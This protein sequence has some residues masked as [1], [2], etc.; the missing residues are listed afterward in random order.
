MNRRL[1]T[2]SWL[3]V[4]AIA[5]TV[6]GGLAALGSAF[7]FTEA[8]AQTHIGNFKAQVVAGDAS[9]ET[10]DAAIT[11]LEVS[12]DKQN[13]MLDNIRVNQIKMMERFKIRH[14]S[15]RKTKER[16]DESR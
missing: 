7:F 8:D 13:L 12:S 5:L 14:E 1:D 10:Q 4:I 6:A 16:T 15:L 2:K 9:D 3:A 11:T